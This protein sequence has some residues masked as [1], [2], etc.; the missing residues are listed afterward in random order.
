MSK[1]NLIGFETQDSFEDALTDVLRS[2]ARRLLARAVDAEVDDDG[3]RMIV[4]NGY[5]HERDI[6]TGIGTVRV[7][8]PRVRDLRSGEDDPIRFTP[9]I[10]P[11]Y[12]RKTKSLE[13]L[14]P[15][16][17]LK[18]IS[19]GDFTESLTA[20]LGKDA[21]GLSPSTISRLKEG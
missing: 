20:L 10:L 1:D 3:C 5:H 9:R 15:W 16:L 17:Y 8:A 21:P 19:T 12:L 11:P 4:R 13:E 2:G 7:K 6:Q 18:G 14:I